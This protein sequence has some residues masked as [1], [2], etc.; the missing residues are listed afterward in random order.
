MGL[1][2]SSGTKVNWLTLSK[3]EQLDEL[4]LQSEEKPVLIFKHS[5]RCSISRFALNDFEYD[6]NTDWN[7]TC[8]FLDL[9][10]H[11]DISNLIAEQLN[12]VHQSPQ[13]ILV[14]NREVVYHASHQSISAEKISLHLTS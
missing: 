8:Y 2:S 1:F 14:K 12:V 10:A 13:V 9:L 7:C 3:A 5:T 4:L 6:W 11:R